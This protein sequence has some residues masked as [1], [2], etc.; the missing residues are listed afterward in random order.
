M[1]NLNNGGANHWYDL[2]MLLSLERAD[3]YL[4]KINFPL[5][6][7]SKDLEQTARKFVES[8]HE[9]QLQG[10]SAAQN[11]TD[12]IQKLFEDTYDLMSRQMGDKNAEAV[13]NWGNSLSISADVEYS[14]RTYEELLFSLNSEDVT[15]RLVISKFPSVLLE[16]LL[17]EIYQYRRDSRETNLALDAIDA[18]PKSDWENWVYSTLNEHEPPDAPSMSPYDKLAILIYNVSRKHLLKRIE[19][20]LSKGELRELEAWLNSQALQIQEQ[21]SAIYPHYKLYSLTELFEKI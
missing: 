1:F 11:T 16:R 17:S 20:H 4:H 5:E 14:L 9:F 18:A 7:K 10:Y 21:S 8:Y 2:F 15:S 6:H 19:S 13:C 3:P 12:K